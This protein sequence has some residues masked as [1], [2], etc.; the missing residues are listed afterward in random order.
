MQKFLG[1]KFFVWDIDLRD[2]QGKPPLCNTSDLNEELGQIEYLFSDKTGTLTKNLMQFRCCSI[3]AIKF[4]YAE[5]KL[6]K[7]EQVEHITKEHISRRGAPQDTP[8][9]TSPDRNS[10][11]R[12]RSHIS[13]IDVDR[14]N[15]EVTKTQVDVSNLPSALHFFIVLALCH[16]VQVVA[17][18]RPTETDDFPSFG[19]KSK[20]KK[21]KEAGKVLSSKGNSAESLTSPPSNEK[22]Y[23][24]SSPDEKALLES[25]AK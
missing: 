3:N 7:V 17:K 6:Y 16:S 8:G 24:A 18:R 21:R 2:D 4:E 11:E 23:Q 22:E 10:P 14:I 20:K 9:R 12:E 15:L 25:C 5:E 13:S 19:F 1:S